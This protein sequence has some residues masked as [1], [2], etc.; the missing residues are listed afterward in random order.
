[1]S[2]FPDEAMEALVTK[3]LDLS[4]KEMDLPVDVVDLGTASDSSTHPSKLTPA[5]YTT[6]TDPYTNGNTT[7]DSASSYS[8][9]VH[10]KG[11][12]S[13]GGPSEPPPQRQSGC[14]S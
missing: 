6:Q 8:K 7:Y 11:L 1:M 9:L 2:L 4:S 14:C 10:M 5:D 12:S 13:N 3:I